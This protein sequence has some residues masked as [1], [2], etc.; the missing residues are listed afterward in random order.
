MEAAYP[1]G[2]GTATNIAMTVRFLL[3]N[4][5]G[6]ITGQKIIVDGGRSINLS[7]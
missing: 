3:S 2:L 6:W 4:E 7:G 5:S 1:L